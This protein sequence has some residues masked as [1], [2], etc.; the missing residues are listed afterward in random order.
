MILLRLTAI[1]AW[2]FMTWGALQTV[3]AF[4]I[5]YSH[6]DPVLRS[7]LTMRYFRVQ[8]PEL[9]FAW[10][11]AFFILGLVLALFVRRAMNK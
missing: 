1:G 3:W 10:G 7:F 4:D 2:F 6:D 11:V 5:A 8:S 9:A